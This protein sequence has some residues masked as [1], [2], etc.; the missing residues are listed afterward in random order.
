[1]WGYYKKIISIILSGSQNY[2]LVE[3]IEA[4]I[5]NL[6]LLEPL[7]IEK[8]LDLI[9][10][11][12]LSDSDAAIIATKIEFRKKSTKNN[13]TMLYAL[14]TFEAKLQRKTAI[15]KPWLFT[16]FFNTLWSYQ[17]SFNTISFNNLSNIICCI[18][19]SQSHNSTM[20]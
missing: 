13:K 16:E 7:S 20:V 15:E 17:N 12:L 19:H 6:D 18:E 11:N 2:R 14:N 5:H 10:L 4:I 1:M 9:N 8:I 3:L